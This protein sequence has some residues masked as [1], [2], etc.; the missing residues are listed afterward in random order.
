MVEFLPDSLA[1]KFPSMEASADYLAFGL[2]GLAAILAFFA[3]RMIQNIRLDRV[4]IPG[5]VIQFIGVF[6][7]IFSTNLYLTI[8]AAVFTA[9]AFSFVNV[10]GLPFALSHLSVRH[11]TLWSRNVYWCNRG[12][13]RHHGVLF[14]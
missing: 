3:G 4:L 11:I 10:S 12:S 5:F 9:G 2:L 1:T 6:V 7:I 8:A 13:Y 14:A